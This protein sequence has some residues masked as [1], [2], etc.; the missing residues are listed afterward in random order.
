MAPTD[1]QD[2]MDQQPIGELTT[3]RDK[4]YVGWKVVGCLFGAV[5]VWVSILG[6]P[7]GL[8]HGATTGD[9]TPL[10]AVVVFTVVL[11]IGFQSGWIE[12]LND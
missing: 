5:G 7:I 6:I 3:T 2:G 11:L 9:W 12:S 8:Y 4:L 10:G 1:R